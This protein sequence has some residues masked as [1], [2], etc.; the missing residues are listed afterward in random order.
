VII[1]DVAVW[2]SIVLWLCGS[3]WWLIWRNRPIRFGDNAHVT[4]ARFTRP[5]T[6]LGQAMV[7]DSYFNVCI[8]NATS[9]AGTALSLKGN[10][11]SPNINPGI[12]IPQKPLPELDLTFG[13]EPLIAY[14]A[15]NCRPFLRRDGTRELTLTPVGIPSN[16][17]TIWP[18]R[19]RAEA[20]CTYCLHDAPMPDCECGLWAMRTRA[21]V[22]GRGLVTGEVALWGRVI[23][24]R[25]G[26]RAQY[27]Y[28]QRLWLEGTEDERAELERLYG[29]P[30]ELAKQDEV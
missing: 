17:W 15:W 16:R 22:R 7:K 23:E 30:V 28:P 25:D 19:R 5:V 29:I 3:A 10:A 13:T 24:F 6:F 21:D 12:P 8:F 20:F 14:R 27:A 26:Y 2:T 11:V 4:N 1:W 18:S 9:G